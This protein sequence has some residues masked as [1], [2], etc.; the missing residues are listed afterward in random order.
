MFTGIIEEVGKLLSR[1]QN[2]KNITLSISAHSIL[3]TVKLGDSISSNGVC[4]TVTKL[5]NTSFHADLMPESIKRSTFNTVSI[6][7]PINLERALQANARLDGHIVAGHVDCIERLQEI[8]TLS[9]SYELTFSLNAK[10]R[11]YMIEK[12][13]V[14]IN[15]ISLTI[16]SVRNNSFTVGIIPHTY[17]VTN[18]HTLSIGSSVN[19]EFDQLGKYILNQSKASTLDLDTLT[20]WGY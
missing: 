14:A 17:K 19:I 2:G 13:S 3:D 20:R 10:H 8:K 5:E 6:G 15:G 4:L 9:E 7:S 12:G 1:K 11:I 18:L 16:I